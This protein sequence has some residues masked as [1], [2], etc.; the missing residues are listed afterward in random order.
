MH[1]G[2]D[3][4][5]DMHTHAQAFRTVELEIGCTDSKPL[6]IEHL[7]RDTVHFMERVDNVATLRLNFEEDA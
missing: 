4:A 5:A 6:V 3:G 2:N 1:L 7:K